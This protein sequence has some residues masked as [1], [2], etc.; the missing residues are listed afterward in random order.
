MHEFLKV[1]VRSI[2][3]QLAFHPVAFVISGGAIY[4]DIR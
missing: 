1:I 4:T 2:S 3:V